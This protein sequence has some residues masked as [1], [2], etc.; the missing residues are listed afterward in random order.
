MQNHD[1]DL[2]NLCSAPSVI[3]LVELDMANACKI[4]VWK[5]EMGSLVRICHERGEIRVRVLRHLH[6][7]CAHILYVI[8]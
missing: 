5:G 4:L 7:N 3:A 2:Q 6:V 8:M 1:P